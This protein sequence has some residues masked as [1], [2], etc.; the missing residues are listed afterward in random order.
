[1]PTIDFLSWI[2]R[3]IDCDKY[4][5]VLSLY[6]AIKYKAPD[7]SSPAWNVFIN[8]SIVYVRQGDGETLAIVSE[9][10][11]ETFLSMLDERCGGHSLGRSISKA[12]M[13]VAYGNIMALH[14]YYPWH[15]G[16]NPKFDEV[17]HLILNNL[18]Q[19]K[20]D[21]VKRFTSELNL[22]IPNDVVVCI[23]PPHTPGS[24]HKKAMGLI[25]QKLCKQDRILGARCLYRHIRIEKLTYGGSREK[26]IHENSII[27]N[28][29][30]VIKNKIIWLLD[31]VVKT[32]NS[33]RICADKLLNNKA[34]EVHCIALGIT[35]GI[36]VRH[37]RQVRL[38]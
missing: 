36:A 16:S 7:I 32:G 14:K 31:D 35:E 6:E 8:D 20:R 5:D 24:G 12:E 10:A 27:V 19:S 15:G 2:D 37:I 1:M 11:V 25:A 28:N 23:V 34:R 22:I 30:Y 3:Y 18:K 29:N 4:E 38:K 9:N 26:Q 13:F 33:M 17:S 21:A